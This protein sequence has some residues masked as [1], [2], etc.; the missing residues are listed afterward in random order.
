MAKWMLRQHASFLFIRFLCLF[1]FLF[2][3]AAFSPQAEAPRPGISHIPY[4]VHE[5][6]FPSRKLEQS[7]ELCMELALLQRSQKSQD[8]STVGPRQRFYFIIIPI[9]PVVQNTPKILPLLNMDFKK[10]TTECCRS[11]KWLAS[12][13]H[14]PLQA[15][16]L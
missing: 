1:V 12:I 11:T 6:A 15:R 4:L 9:F 2:W 5:E 16:G 3:F 13:A 8:E 14:A 10:S 7:G